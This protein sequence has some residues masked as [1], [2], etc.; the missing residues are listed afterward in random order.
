MNTLKT[1]QL[2]NREFA[3]IQDLLR[4]NF[5]RKHDSYSYTQFTDEDRKLVY[6]AMKSLRF[7]EAMND[8][9]KYCKLTPPEF[10]ESY[11]TFMKNNFLYE[12][13]LEKFEP[14]E[15]VS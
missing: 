5:D 4:E 11:E 6:D 14:I 12:E 3:L 2:T 7:T 13:D 1:V 10:R 8:Y 15:V 9:V